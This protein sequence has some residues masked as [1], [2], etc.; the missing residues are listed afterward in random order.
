MSSKLKK[1]LFKSLIVSP[2]K[3]LKLTDIMLKLTHFQFNQSKN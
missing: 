3:T 2:I 1:N